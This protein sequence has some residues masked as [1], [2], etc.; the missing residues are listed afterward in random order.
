MKQKHSTRSTLSK[1]LNAIIPLSQRQKKRGAM[2]LHSNL[3]IGSLFEKE[4]DGK[5]LNVIKILLKQTKN[6][7]YPGVGLGSRERDKQPKK[8]KQSSKGST[9]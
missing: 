4:L 1:L 2:T 6:D 9:F 5:R 8:G 7:L 3:A